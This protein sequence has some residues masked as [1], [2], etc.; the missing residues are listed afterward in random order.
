VPAI[1]I[2]C[3]M[4]TVLAYPVSKLLSLYNSDNE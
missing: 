2:T 3:G 1:I 4:N